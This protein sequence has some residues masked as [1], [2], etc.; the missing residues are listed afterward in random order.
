VILPVCSMHDHCPHQSEGVHRQVPLATGDLF[1]CIVASFFAPFCRAN[2]LTVHD[3][4]TG[5]GLLPAVLSDLS[6][7]SLV[8]SLPQAISTP[9]PENGVHRFPLRKVM[10]QCSPLTPRSIDVQDGTQDQPPTNGPSATLR[11]LGQQAPQHLP[12]SIRQIAGI[13][14]AHRYGSVFLDLRTKKAET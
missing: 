1:T 6:A 10:R 7:E 8:D 9:T 4:Y 14:L 13:L 2:R 11:L 5:R 3:R 12:L